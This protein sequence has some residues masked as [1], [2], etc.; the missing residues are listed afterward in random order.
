MSL[1]QEMHHSYQAPRYFN[2][3]LSWLEF[4]QRVLDEACQKTLPLLDRLK[5]LCIVSSNFDEFFMVRVGSL[6]MQ[7]ASGKWTMCPSGLSCDQQ[8]EQI[9][10]RAHEIIDKQYQVFREEVRPGLAK[11]GMHLLDLAQLNKEDIREVV[12]VFHRELFPAMTPIKVEEGKDF[13]LFGNQLLHVI[14]LLQSEANPE[15]RVLGIVPVSPK[16]PRLIPLP[17]KSGELRF[18]FLEEVIR[19]CGTIL[20]PGYKT[21]EHTSFRV[22]RNA[23]MSVDEERDED[24]VK[25]MQEALGLRITSAPVRL[26]VQKGSSMLSKELLSRLQVDPREFYEVDGTLELK[27]LMDLCFLPGFDAM[28][29]PNWP[30]RPIPALEDEESIWEVLARREILLHHPYQSFA[31]VVRMVQ[32]ASNDPQTLAIKCTLYRTSGKSPIVQ[33]LIRAAQKGIQ[34]TVLVELKARFDEEQNIQWANALER[35]GAIVVYGLA[36]LKVHAKAMMIVRREETGIR[37]YVHLGTGNYNEKTAALYTDMGILSSRQELG[38]EVSLFFNAITGYS[39]V[40][41][42][43]LLSMAPLTMKRRLIQ[44]IEREIERSTPQSPG[45]IIA[46]MNSLAHPE[47]IEAL[48][49][50]SRAGVKILLN[51][52]GICQIVPGLPVHSENI[53]VVS[54][55]DRYLEHTRAFYFQNGGAEEVFLASADWMPRNLDRRVE[56]LFPVLDPSARK[57][58]VQSLKA[59]FK[60]NQHAHELQTDGS[61][62]RIKKEE[63]AKAFSVQAYFYESLG[64]KSEDEENEVPMFR[65]RRKAPK[66]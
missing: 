29:L 47:V 66:V 5:F 46:K 26:S 22:I 36:N 65:V 27:G 54:V 40:L 35:A 28:R 42:L 1:S 49:A 38:D 13:P 23:D 25:A 59:Y 2:R 21:V 51:V 58:V 52:R 41:P 50:A 20:F 64:K 10:I 63:G 34:V 19:L 31:P 8:L 9:S 14:F 61:W 30:A 11:N 24:F 55:I 45:L 57:Q 60:D 3:E 39:S 17:S 18:T 15:E 4:N 12:D 6:L 33:S 7:K 16:L 32:E 37:R 44:L 48:Y 53:R 43:D 56:L 62:K